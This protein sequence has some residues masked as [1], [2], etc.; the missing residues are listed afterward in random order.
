MCQ[1][2]VALRYTRSVAKI[3]VTGGAGY[4]GSHTRYFLQERGHSVVVADN[5]S[6]GYKDAVP[7]DI[8][9][10]IDI[11]ETEKMERLLKKERVDAVIHF[12]AYIGVGRAPEAPDRYFANN[13]RRSLSLLNAMRRASLKCLV[14][15]TTEAS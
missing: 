3:L 5:L 4:I 7:A 15:S 6:R 12:A 11:A 13:V 1:S 14:F 10:V 9:R 2:T 8:L